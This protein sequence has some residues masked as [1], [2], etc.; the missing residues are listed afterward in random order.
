[1]AHA[2]VEGSKLY[3]EVH[4]EDRPGP[5]LV[6]LMGTG[7]TCQGWL[8]LQ[9]PE[10]APAHRTVI[11]DYPGT[12][13]SESRDAPF[14]TAGLADT[15]AGLLDALEI[16]RAHVLGS[17]MGGMVAQELALR[18][19]DRVERLVLVGTYA[20]PDAKRRTLLTQWS[21]LARIDAPVEM[22]VRERLLWTLQDETLEQGDLIDAMVEFFTRDRAPMDP[23]IFSRQCEACIAH[24]CLDRLREIDKP[25]LILCGRGDQLTPPKFHRQLADEIANARLVTFAHCGH[26]VMAES[27]K[28]FNRTV[29]QFL[30]EHTGA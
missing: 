29:L 25:T 1:V 27:A 6:L 13:Q 18:W 16:D 4:G 23:E 30:E 7:G 19:P 8:P 28:P 5:P 15:T 17:F 12:G 22:L 20:R 11:F 24:D 26:L 2:V 9:D 10:F 21:D 14:S 3:Y